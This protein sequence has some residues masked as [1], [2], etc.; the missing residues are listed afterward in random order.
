MR[1]AQ[2]S[3]TGRGAAVVIPFIFILLLVT[4]DKRGLTAEPKTGVI[5]VSDVPASL[6]SI[7]GE[8]RLSFR[9]DMRD[10]GVWLVTSPVWVPVMIAR[11]AFRRR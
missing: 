8:E 2:G 5:D 3:H 10:F 6:E 11:T 7:P 4:P 1:V 9:R